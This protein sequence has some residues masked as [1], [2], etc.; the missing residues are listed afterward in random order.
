MF[1]EHHLPSG[2]PSYINNSHRK[3][4]N[5]ML[6]A[7][8][9]RMDRLEEALN[10]SGLQGEVFS[11]ALQKVFDPEAEVQAIDTMS[12]EEIADVA[13]ML[14]SGIKAEPRLAWP[15]AETLV[16]TAFVTRKEW[17]SIRML[18]LGGSDAAV[19]CGISPYTS[20]Q[21][22]Y[23]NKVGT[24]FTITEA[25]DPGKEYIFAYGHRMEDLV[26]EQFCRQTGA[27]RVAETRMFRSKEHPFITA[28]IDAIV[29]FPDGRLAIFEAKTT[30]LFNRDA[31]ADH[32]CP[33]HYVPQCRQ[34]PIVLN[35][36]RIAETYIGCIYGNTP[37]DFMSGIVERDA[38]AEQELVESECFFWSDYIEAG[39]EPPP[40]GNADLDLEMQRKKTGFAD[41]TSKKKPVDLDA[42]L[43]GP[44]SEY[45]E[46]REKRRNAEKVVESLKE[47]EAHYQLPVV[48]A[49]GKNIVGI[50]KRPNGGGYRVTYNPVSRS[51]IDT[52]KLALLYPEAYAACVSKSKENYR[53]F[54][55]KE[56][57][58]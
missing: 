13:K 8:R 36:P 17:E 19:V 53:T 46:I 39:I 40:S 57:G 10:I 51:S 20:Q 28:N 33:A 3:P 25:T 52:E 55:V 43:A 14:S 34:Y 12:A 44:L 16:D 30:T 4:F 47:Q 21:G 23:H 9:G 32:S 2:M 37:S 31:W 29:R 15:N 24:P 7:V 56:W 5:A 26:I 22:L 11:L 48:E 58:V 1:F 49:L 18:G 35:D 50:V 45:M 6:K 42:S 38:L 54:A 41:V 27:V